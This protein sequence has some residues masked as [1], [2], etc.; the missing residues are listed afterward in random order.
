M[1]YEKLKDQRGEADRQLLLQP[2][3]VTLEKNEYAAVLEGRALCEQAGF[4]IEDFGPGTVLVRTVPLILGT[5]DIAG[6]VMEIAGYLLR[7]KQD[8][9][10]EK[11]DWLYH[12]VACRAA[13][14]AGDE[15]S[16]AELIALADRLAAHPEIRYC[17]HGRPVSVVFARRE[18]EKQFGRIQ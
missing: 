3:P 11:L 5:D 10:T 7:S 13:V 2:I 17:P 4:E 15:S 16:P 6:T 14:K 12:N 18:L 9:T 1:I 8:L